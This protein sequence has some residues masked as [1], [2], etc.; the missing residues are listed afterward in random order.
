MRAEA[1]AVGWLVSPRFDGAVFGGPVLLS[2]GLLLLEPWWAPTGRVPLS[3]WLFGVL[4]VD[5][6]HVWATLFVTYLDPTARR[7]FRRALWVCPMAATALALGLAWVAAEHYWRVL[8]YLAVFHFIRQQ[9]G[10]VRLYQRREAALPA[11]E[12]QLDGAAVYAAALYPVIWWHAHLPRRFAWFESG[13]FVAGL[14][15]PELAEALFVPYAGLL[16]AFAAVQ[17]GRLA[18]RR[19]VAVGKGLVVAG[20][21]ACWGIGICLTDSDWGFTVT[22]VFLHGIPYV[23]FVWVQARRSPTSPVAAGPLGHGL[24]FL[25]GLV[26]LAYLEEW[27]WDRLLWHE[28]G[29]FPGPAIELGPGGAAV[30]L[31]VLS[32]PQLTHYLLDGIIWRRGTPRP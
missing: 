10:W 31:A 24:G 9:Y 17:L 5:V 20:T 23:A 21:A 4:A 1:R 7:R 11:W 29:V 18:S 19:P 25:A 16:L 6:A 2:L 3:M 27:G 22:N 12:R 14:V 15:T 28:G 8:A 30:A 32:V 26:G 13:D